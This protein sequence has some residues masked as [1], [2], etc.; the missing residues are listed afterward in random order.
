LGVD[1]LSAAF[2]QLL[3]E[4][5]GTQRD[6]EPDGQDDEQ[7][8][9]E[10]AERIPEHLERRLDR[11]GH[12]Q[13]QAD[14]LRDEGGERRPGPFRP[15]HDERA[16]GQREPEDRDEARPEPEEH[17]GGDEPPLVRRGRRPE[18]NAG[19]RRGEDEADQPSLH[20]IT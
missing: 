18:R 9:R 12:E 16:D 10:R 1:P 2:H 7:D 6:D 4:R 17:A 3:F 20:R 5:A 11:V 19:D 14:E 13:E 15:A 8:E